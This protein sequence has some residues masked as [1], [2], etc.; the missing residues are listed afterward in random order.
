M[1]QGN[2]ETSEQYSMDG[3][4]EN[5]SCWRELGRSLWVMVGDSL[6]ARESCSFWDEQAEGRAE[7]VATQGLSICVLNVKMSGPLLNFAAASFTWIIAL[8]PPENPKNMN[9]LY[10][11]KCLFSIWD[12]CPRVGGKWVV[13]HITSPFKKIFFKLYIAAFHPYFWRCCHSDI[14]SP[15]KRA[16]LNLHVKRDDCVQF[17]K[18]AWVMLVLSPAIGNHCSRANTVYLKRLY[19]I[20]KMASE[21]TSAWLWILTLW[22][23]QPC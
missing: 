13:G 9:S 12:D 20:S 23:R 2:G 10:F 19:L 3:D 7:M 22:G 17:E 16:C 5:N 18:I 1:L 14:P 15:I 6:Q 21:P 4:F 8:F 11:L